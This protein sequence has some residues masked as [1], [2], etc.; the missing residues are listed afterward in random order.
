MDWPS[1]LSAALAGGLAAA[2]A[3]LLVGRSR[4]R[5]VP[6]IIV[7][8]VVFFGLK[9]FADRAL[10]PR[11]RRWHTDRQLREMPFYSD[12]AEMDSPTYKKVLDI[13]SE[14]ATKGETGDA[15][16]GRIAPVLSNIVP[17]YIGKASDESVIAF[18]DLFTKEIKEL[19][20]KRSDGCYYFMFP[21]EEGAP[22]A[23]SYLNPK[24]NPLSL[25]VLGRVLHSSAHSPQAA[26]DST[27]AEVLLQPVLVSMQTDYGDDLKLLVQ[28]P[29]DSLGR[30]KVCAISLALYGKAGS[31]PRNDAALL[32]RYLL[33][34]Q[35]EHPPAP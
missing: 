13:A 35:K 4:D 26:P 14:S 25:D 19:H 7:L 5:R 17:K 22:P 23:S 30:Q 1:I 34:D 12:L 33:A 10:V 16:A 15:I 9:V 2:I 27:R 21:T 29:T 32:L 24:Y 11:V 6:Y 28:K 3:T 8:I 18:V 31:L 20:D